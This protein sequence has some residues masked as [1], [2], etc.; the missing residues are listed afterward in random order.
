MVSK[1]PII[2]KRTKKF[3]RFHS[4]QFKT[5]GASWRRPRGIDSRIRRRFRGNRPMP[6]IGYGS[7]KATKFMLPNG[8]KKFLINRPEDLE[9]LL[10]HRQDYAAEVAHAV[11]AKKRLA[12]VARAN[13]LGITLTNGTARL[14]AA[15]TQ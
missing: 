9:M 12:I 13:E 3:I 14:V 6:K 1:K 7:D 2:K 5:V 4:D 15:E 11:G 8:M 10:M